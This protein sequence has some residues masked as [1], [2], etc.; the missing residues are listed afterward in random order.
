MTASSFDPTVD[1]AHASPVDMRVQ[2]AREACGWAFV[3][4]IRARPLAPH[5][6]PF[7]AGGQ[8]RRLP[9]V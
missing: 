8:L 1:E 7:S 3:S 9:G 6:D 5:F 4:L 2:I